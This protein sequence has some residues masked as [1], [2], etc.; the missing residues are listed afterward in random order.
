MTYPELRP[1]VLTR[2]CRL[3]LKVDAN[4]AELSESCEL[5]RGFRRF[6]RRDL[7]VPFAAVTTAQRVEQNAFQP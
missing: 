1:A 3:G 5:H 6:P 7:V 4:E 2:R